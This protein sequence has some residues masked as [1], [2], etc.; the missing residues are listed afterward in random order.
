MG[1]FVIRV[2]KLDQLFNEARYHLDIWAFVHDLAARLIPHVNRSGSPVSRILLEVVLEHH[3]MQA[4]DKSLAVDEVWVFR[5]LK[6][7]SHC[8]SVSRHCKPRFTV[9]V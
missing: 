8:S 1:T 9:C 3:E 2:Q 5:Q 4:A 7:E 6:H